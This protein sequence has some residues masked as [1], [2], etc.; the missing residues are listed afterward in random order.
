ML[1]NLFEKGRGLEYLQRL[2][3]YK[4]SE[5]KEGVH[6]ADKE[7]KLSIASYDGCLYS[8]RVEHLKASF[9]IPYSM[10]DQICFFVNDFWHLGLSEREVDAYNICKCSNY[11]QDNVILRSLY[12]VLC[13][14]FEK[15]GNEETASEKELAILRNA[16]EHKYVKVHENN[17]ERKLQIE[18]DSFYHIS[19]ENLIN[20][21]M[22]LLQI[23]REALMYLVY[24]IGVN[25]SKKEKE[26]RAVSMNLM[27]YPD[28]CKI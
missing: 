17:W 4:G 22:R 20:Q 10:L 14:F 11:P 2:L 26:G 19:E 24:A 8:V 13:E 5:M 7:T 25:E 15:Y 21:T 28:E 27:D 18:K 23:S 12:W 3:L 1:I 16:L 6:F 9:R